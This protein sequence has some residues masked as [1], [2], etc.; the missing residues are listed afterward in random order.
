MIEG[1]ENDVANQ[2]SARRNQCVAFLER[3]GSDRA[4][5]QRV[6]KV[7]WELIEY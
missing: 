3:E 5:H 4:L 1:S 7:R 2:E 6:K